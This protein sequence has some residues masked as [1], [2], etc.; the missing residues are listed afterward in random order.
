MRAHRQ[1][2]SNL[3]PIVGGKTHLAEPV[4]D[5]IGSAVES[6]MRSVGAST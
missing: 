4:H 5:Q 2:G 3:M 1:I 6:T